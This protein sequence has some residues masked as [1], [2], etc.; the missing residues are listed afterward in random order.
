[1]TANYNWVKVIFGAWG[2]IKFA[3]HVWGLLG[4][5]IM[6]FTAIVITVY[7]SKLFI[8][9]VILWVHQTTTM[10]VSFTLRGM[11]N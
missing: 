4:K 6:S 5:F 9:W 8:F 7:K 3:Y 1:M 2:K 10:P 11:Q